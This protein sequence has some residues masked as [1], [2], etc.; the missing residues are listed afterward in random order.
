M[1]QRM[2]CSQMERTEIRRA[3][4]SQKQELEE[5]RGV[6]DTGMHESVEG[7]LVS[8]QRTVSAGP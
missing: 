4:A 8:W 2:K 3:R 1:I 6:P 5:C 7:C